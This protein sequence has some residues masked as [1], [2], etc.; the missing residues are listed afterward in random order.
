MSSVTGWKGV[1]DEIPLAGGVAGWVPQE[2]A[3]ITNKMINLLRR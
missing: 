2:E 3:K 1:G